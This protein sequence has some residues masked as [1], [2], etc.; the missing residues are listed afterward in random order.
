MVELGKITFKFA[1]K[2]D[3]SLVEQFCN[4]QNF[5]NNTDLQK[6][7]WDWCLDIG[8]W[9]IAIYEDRIISLAGLHPLPEIDNNSFRCLFRGAQLPGYSVGVGKNIFKSSIHLSHFLYYQ[10]LWGLKKNPHGKFYISTN[11]NN[12]GGK[13]QRMNNVMGPWLA[14]HHNILEAEQ[15]LML[16]G[17]PQTLWR[18]KVENYFQERKKYFALDH[19]L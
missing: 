13:S 14:K 11:I 18:I 5:T 17:V 8:V 15:T 10:L 7:K 9:N 3:E 16:Y 1:T 19:Q 4:S 6:M 12:D 2:E